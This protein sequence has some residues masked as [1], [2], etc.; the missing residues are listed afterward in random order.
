MSIALEEIKKVVSDHY[1]KL[2]VELE[3]RVL[4][5]TGQ[6]A[7]ANARVVLCKTWEYWGPSRY[8]VQGFYGE[9]SD[10]SRHLEELKQD[11]EEARKSEK[12]A[13]RI[14]ENLKEGLP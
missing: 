9:I 4:N 12:E 8:E 6:I 5:V 3:M 10:L 14:M 7:A 11:L 13:A 2:R 1:R